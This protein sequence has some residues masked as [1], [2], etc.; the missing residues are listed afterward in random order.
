MRTSS[1]LYVSD[2]DRAGW[3]RTQDVKDSLSLKVRYILVR[4]KSYG[5]GSALVCRICI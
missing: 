3:S 2:K 1:A 5:H 4:R